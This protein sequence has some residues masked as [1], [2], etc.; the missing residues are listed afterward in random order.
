MQVDF[1]RVRDKCERDCLIELMRA[2][3]KYFPGDPTVYAD[4]DPVFFG[5]PTRPA[6]QGTMVINATG[7]RI[8]SFKR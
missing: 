8:R 6:P 3:E 4:T 5:D 2:P 1:T 7:Q